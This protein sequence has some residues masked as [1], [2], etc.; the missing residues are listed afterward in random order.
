MY[1]F[2]LEAPQLLQ[3][4]SLPWLRAARGSKRKLFSLACPGTLQVESKGVCVV[5]IYFYIISDCFASSTSLRGA[6]LSYFYFI[7]SAIGMLSLN[8]S[9][10][11]FF[12]IPPMTAFV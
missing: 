6:S 5:S 1:I 11:M 12:I 8:S 3:K 7:F 4:R 2:F 10:V 9:F